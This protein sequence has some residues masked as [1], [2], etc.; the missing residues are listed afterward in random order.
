LKQQLAS[1]KKVVLVSTYQSFADVFIILF[2]LFVNE[3]EIPFTFGSEWSGIKTIDSLLRQIG[4]VSSNRSE[5][6]SA[7]SE[8]INFALIKESVSNHNL[9]LIFQNDKRL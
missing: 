8:Y 6:Q 2:C 3:I 7:Q 9:T 5:T 1:G 4:F